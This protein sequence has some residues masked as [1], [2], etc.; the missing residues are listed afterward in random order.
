MSEQEVLLR[1]LYAPEHIVDGNV[2]ETAI[3]LKDLK[4]RGVSLDR[5]SYVEKEIIKKRIEA[6][7]S[8]APDERQEASLSK[9][10]C[11]D[12][13]NINNNNDQVF[14]IIDDATQTNIAH[15]SIF[16]IKGSCPPRKARAELVRCLQDRQSLS[17]LIP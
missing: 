13:R 14:L 9:F 17:S 10:S 4:C 3:S 2:I 1:L 16:L 11:S 6:Q 15:A 12:I 5:L 7:T 8:K